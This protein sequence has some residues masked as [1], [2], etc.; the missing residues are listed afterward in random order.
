MSIGKRLISTWC[1]WSFCVVYVHFWQSLSLSQKHNHSLFN[2]YAAVTVSLELNRRPTYYIINIIV[3]SAF[4]GYLSLFV[5]L[6]PSESGEKIS[7]LQVIFLKPN[8]DLKCLLWNWFRPKLCTFFILMVFS[9]VLHG[10]VQFFFIPQCY[11]KVLVFVWFF[12]SHII[13]TEEWLLSKTLWY[14]VVAGNYRVILPDA[15]T[16]CWGGHTSR[17]KTDSLLR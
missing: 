11:Q 6:L 15:V 12:F 2:K 8:Y 17:R 9:M 7:S 1:L 14:C 16:G 4:L 13:M 3:P 10:P 5:F